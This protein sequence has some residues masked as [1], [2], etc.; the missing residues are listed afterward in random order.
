MDKLPKKTAVAKKIDLMLRNMDFSQ[1]HEPTVWDKVLSRIEDPD[2]ELPLFALDNVAGGHSNQ[3]DED[4]KDE[5][6][7]KK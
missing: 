1:G 7:R 4:E 3:T 2:V 5:I 6:P